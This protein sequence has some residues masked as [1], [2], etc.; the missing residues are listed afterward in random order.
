MLGKDHL[1]ISIAFILTFLIP[2]FFIFPEKTSFILIIFLSVIIGSILPDS[3]CKG[4]ATIAHRF[5]EIDKIT[6]KFV[7]KPIIF[8]L[9]FLIKEGKINVEH[10]VN[11]EHR[12]ILHSPTG[13]VLSSILLMIFLT[14]LLIIFDLFNFKIVLT[15]F[16]G[17]IIGQLLHLFEDSCTIMGINWGF[18][19]KTKPLKG[20]IYTFSRGV[21]KKDIRPKMYSAIFYF[22]GII[23]FLG[24]SFAFL[25][26]ISIFLVYALILAYDVFAIFLII[27]ISQSDSSLW[28]KTKISK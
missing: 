6:R 8:F 16:A 28:A 13:V 25:T 4:K 10:E 19:F 3:D 21:G 23:L 27:K 14:I 17:L 1:N 22:L 26:N 11:D 15:I 12:G 7:G 24:Y 20:K 5:P 2:A 9:N 18:P